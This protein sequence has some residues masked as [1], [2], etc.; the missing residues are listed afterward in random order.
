M[1]VEHGGNVVAGIVFHNW[2]PE[3]GIVEISGASENPRWFTRRVINAAL[4][5]AFDGLK[6]QMIVARQAVENENPRRCWK[7]LGGNEYIIPRLRGRD[8]DG[9]IIT[10]T[11]EAWRSSKFYK[12]A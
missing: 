6:C 1:G 5:Y 7:A 11:D 9:S 10:L 12:E 8:K 2:E 4:T 3:T